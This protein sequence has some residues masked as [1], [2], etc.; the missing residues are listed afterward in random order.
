MLWW[1]TEREP[2]MTLE[3]RLANKPP[4][5]SSVFWVKQKGDVSQTSIKKW[6]IAILNCPWLKVQLWSLQSQKFA[7]TDSQPTGQWTQPPDL[8]QTRQPIPNTM[9][10]LF[11]C[12]VFSV[13]YW[14][15][16]SA[17]KIL[18]KSCFRIDLMTGLW[19]W[20]WILI[21]DSRCFSAVFIVDSV[22]HI[23]FSSQSTRLPEHQ[24][25]NRE[26]NW[27]LGFH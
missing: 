9:T 3:Q 18:L 7:D 1:M 25:E 13:R 24:L 14:I 2:S 16:M 4:F 26:M 20:S 5:F 23:H 21:P 6:R 22:N 15:L 27:L 17:Y 12:V 10:Q 8:P 11:C 19:F